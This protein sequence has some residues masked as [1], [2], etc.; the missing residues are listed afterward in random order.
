MRD[1]GLHVHMK[2]WQG[3]SEKEGSASFSLHALAST[4]IPLFVLTASVSH[5]SYS[6]CLVVSVLQQGQPRHFCLSK[7]G[8]EEVVSTKRL[9]ARLLRV[10][11]T[12]ETRLAPTLLFHIK[13]WAMS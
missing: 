10:P 1:T 7:E 3:C 6:L 4:S 5:C 13:Q 12:A 11:E 2:P 9:F 8:A